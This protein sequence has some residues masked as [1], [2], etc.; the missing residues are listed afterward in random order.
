VPEKHGTRDP[1]QIRISI[2]QVASRGTKDQYS[3]SQSIGTSRQAESV[4]WGGRRLH[5]ED[6][7]VA[8][9]KQ[10]VFSRFGRRN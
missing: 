5:G 7:R 10:A 2:S 9:M 1:N 3:D 6:Y 4:R 8:Q